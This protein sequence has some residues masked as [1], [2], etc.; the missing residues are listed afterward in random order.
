MS[1]FAV[2]LA[3]AGI[4]VV[5]FGSNFLP[6]KK[7]KTGNGIFFQWVMCSAVV[8][9]G[10]VLYIVQCQLNNGVCPPFEPLAMLGGAIWACGNIWVVT[11]IKCI[12]LGLG[13]C[14][15]GSS[16][17]LIGWASGRFGILGVNQQSVSNSGLNYAGIGLAVCAMLTFMFVKPSLEDDDAGSSSGGARYGKLPGDDRDAEEGLYSVTGGGGMSVPLRGASS[18]LNNGS[19]SSGGGGGAGG[20]EE[21]E[22]S[23]VDNL[24]PAAKSTLGITLSIISGLCYGT[25]FNPPQYIADHNGPN[26]SF[27]GAPGPSDLWKYVFPHF[28]GI[29]L[30]STVFTL[31]YAAAARNAPR[32]YPQIV[33][34]GFIS[35]VIWAIAQISFFIANSKLSFVV[36]FP[37]I[38]V[39]PGLVGALWGT[40][41]F[42]ETKG[43]R[44]YLLLVAAFAFAIGSSTLIALSK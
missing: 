34:P 44:N 9:T 7:Y 33:L 30:A 12:G 20:E 15:W 8:L 11:I 36:S 14:L 18:S 13:L 41:V 1:D 42:R 35:G 29:F 38:A 5:F 2:G 40:L 43:M 6:V 10:L 24:P 26:D 25:N 31:I 39:G 16:N 17:M 21:E 32:L 37:L 22:R 27:P 19:S 23:W 3:A 4:A 28:C